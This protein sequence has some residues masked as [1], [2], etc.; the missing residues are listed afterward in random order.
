VFFDN[1]NFQPD[2]QKPFLNNTVPPGTEFEIHAKYS[3][4]TGMVNAS[5]FDCRSVPMRNYSFFS[6]KYKSYEDHRN[7]KNVEDTR[8]NQ[9]KAFALGISIFAFILIVVLFSKYKN[10]ILNL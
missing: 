5:S 2:L 9:N 10:R 1:S 3:R 8:F 7:N 6:I 4:T